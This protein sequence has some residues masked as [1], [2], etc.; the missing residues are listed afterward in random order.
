MPP[1]TPGIP[2]VPQANNTTPAGVAAVAPIASPTPTAQPAMPTAPA[3]VAQPST[4]NFTGNLSSQL[5]NIASYY[6]I[7]RQTALTVGQGQA[8][9]NIAQ[10]QFE[11]QKYQNQ[12]KITN[13]KN[14]LDPYKYTFQKNADGSVTILN[15]VG[16][17]VDIGTYTALTGDNPATALQK[18]GATDE[19]STKFMEAYNNLQNYIQAKIAAS[20]GDATA[21]AEISDYNKANPGLANMELGQLQGA[22]MEQYGSY[23]GMPSGQDTAALSSKGVTPTLTSVNNP[24][25]TS[26]YENTQFFQ[27]L[28]DQSQQYQQSPAASGASTSN[29]S[30]ALSALQQEQ[31]L[32]AA[33]GG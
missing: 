31:A 3:A 4:P 1:A 15:S 26:A 8:Q 16:D 20:N 25:S 19:A 24:Q 27:P 29:P 10:Q 7:P 14:S 32:L 12:I 22:F 17:K 23:F 13:A 30:S 5:G 18:A 2:V 28:L 6:N 21:Q 11:Q 9:G 33:N